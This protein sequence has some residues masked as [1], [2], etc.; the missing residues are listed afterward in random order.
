MHGCPRRRCSIIGFWIVAQ[1][2]EGRV[3]EAA[4]DQDTSA[5]RTAGREPNHVLGTRDNVDE[6]G[7]RVQ[8]GPQTRRAGGPGFGIEELQARGDARSDC[9]HRRARRR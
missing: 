4:R 8:G 3:G 2:D 7:P 1:L 5:E 6:V 9:A